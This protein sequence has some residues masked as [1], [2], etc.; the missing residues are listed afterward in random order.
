[1]ALEMSAFEI[2]KVVFE[3]SIIW[4]LLYRFSIFVKGTRVVPL[5]RGIVVLVI[6]FSLT[7]IL[8]LEVLNWILTKLF[9]ISVI[10]FLVIFQPE[11]RRGL[12]KI[13][14]TYFDL[15]SPVPEEGIVHKISQSL[16]SLAQKR[17]GALVAFERGVGLKTY[18][19]T[20]VRLDA[21]VSSELLNT[22]FAPLGPLHDGGVVV[23]SGR[24]VA[25][26]CIFPLSQHLDLDRSMGTRHRA[27]LGLSEETDAVVVMVSEETGKIAIARGG[28]L[29]TDFEGQDF[30]FVLKNILQ[31]PQKKTLFYSWRHK[32]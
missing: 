22:I 11:I 3:I 4:F 17:I 28:E 21:V 18:S 24:I 6:L 26:G 5:V 16:V 13:G 23:N 19:E 12:S 7:T 15:F 30:S 27:A 1:M 14:Q 32:K 9:A 29:L 25:A 8:N 2:G 31:Q 20:G 10:G